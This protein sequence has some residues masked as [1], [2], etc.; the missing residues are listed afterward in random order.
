MPE[1]RGSYAPLPE[2]VHVAVQARQIRDSDLVFGNVR[3]NLKTF[4]VLV[5][6]M[7]VNLTFF[8]FELL[9]VLCREVDRIIHYDELCQALWR[10]IGRKERR[11]LSVA[12]CR[13]R[14]K[15]EA[16]RPYRVETVRGR[17]YGFIAARP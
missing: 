5:K 16:S 13:L 7:E 9:R 14:A 1:T 2:E 6:D 15:L 8:E 11:R 10:S 12:I 17:G 3:V 4:D